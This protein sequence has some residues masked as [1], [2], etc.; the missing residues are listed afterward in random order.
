LSFEEVLTV[1]LAHSK[2]GYKDVLDKKE[3][4]LNDF[5]E[6]ASDIFEKVTLN[7]VSAIKHLLDPS[8]TSSAVA[9]ICVAP[10][11]STTTPP[12]NPQEPPVMRK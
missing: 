4:N 10:G 11:S 7:H 12:K 5:L 6:R 3:M 8:N 9:E 1:F 2:Q